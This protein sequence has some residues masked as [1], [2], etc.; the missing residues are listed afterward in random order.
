MDLRPK[1]SAASPPEPGTAESRLGLALVGGRRHVDIEIPRTRPVA[2][3]KL[4]RLTRA[5]EERVSY[6]LG[7]WL[8]QVKRSGMPPPLRAELDAQEAVRTVALAV[9]DPADQEKPLATL[10]EWGQAD[11]GQV[12]DV[13][14]RYLD[15]VAESDPFHGDLDAG[16][17]AEI[18]EAV[19]KKDATRL[20]AFGAK[21]L[22][23]FLLGQ[24]SPPE[25]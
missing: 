12:G 21:P 23:A 20:L 17:R 7:E 18:T 3:G 25:I 24:E 4:R 16:V 5:E 11:D 19:K 8:E 6:D 2:R 13:Y 22:T 15:M 10:E 14:R 1:G 9:R